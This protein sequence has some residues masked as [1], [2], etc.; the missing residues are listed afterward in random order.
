MKNSAGRYRQLLDSCPAAMLIHRHG[1]IIY[2]NE[3]LARMLCAES[4]DQLLG[5][6]VLTLLRKQTGWALLPKDVPQDQLDRR[7]TLKMTQAPLT[8]LL[9]ACG[10]VPSESISGR[11]DFT[12][13]TVSPV[14]STHRLQRHLPGASFAFAARPWSHA[15][16]HKSFVIKTHAF[17]DSGAYLT[18]DVS[19]APG[20]SGLR[21]M[22]CSLHSPYSVLVAGANPKVAS[23]KVHGAAWWWSEIT[24]VTF[25]NP[26][27][28]DKREVAGCT[29]TLDEPHLTVEL[30]IPAME[31]FDF[32]I[33]IPLQP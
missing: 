29:L 31:P 16:G 11:W 28:G 4:R 25:K 2:A 5:R 32:T 24:L 22:R 27:N 1:R 6:E 15:R 8:H 30:R 33:P 20:Q 19:L 12:P 26:R 23:I 18:W 9:A 7:L 14:P 13:A 10:L 17:Q 3:A 21:M